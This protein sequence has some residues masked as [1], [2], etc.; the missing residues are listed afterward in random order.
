MPITWM[1]F[2]AKSLGTITTL[3]VIARISL[4]MPRKI[5]GASKGKC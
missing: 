2:P 4:K 5:F 1:Q 3:S